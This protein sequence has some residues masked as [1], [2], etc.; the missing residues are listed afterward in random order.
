V[1][2]FTAKDRADKDAFSTHWATIR[3]DDSVTIRTIVVD[4]QV[5]GHVLRFDE[6]GHPEVS[7]WLGKDYWGQGIAT[8]A[9]AAFLDHARSR[10]LSARAAK[11]NGASIRVPQKL[12]LRTSGPLTRVALRAKRGQRFASPSARTLYSGA[13]MILLAKSSRRW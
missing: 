8:I 12:G 1:A 2:A 7:Y 5:A 10:P 9:L 3:G 6:A 11:D 4:G 13:R